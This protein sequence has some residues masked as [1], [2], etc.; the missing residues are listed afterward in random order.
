MFASHWLTFPLLKTSWT[1]E[2]K[3]KKKNVW[4]LVF[5]S[6]YFR[7]HGENCVDFVKCLANSSII[8]LKV[9]WVDSF[10]LGCFHFEHNGLNDIIR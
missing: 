1:V 4:I 8:T 6:T 3:V 10:E 5:F 2:K 9:K 7:K